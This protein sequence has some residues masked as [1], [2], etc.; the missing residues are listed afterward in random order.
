MKGSRRKEVDE[1]NWG[2]ETGVENECLRKTKK[3]V[4]KIETSIL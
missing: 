1:T 4:Y 2:D 3:M